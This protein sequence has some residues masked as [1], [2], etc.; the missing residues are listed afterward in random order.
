MLLWMSPSIISSFH[1]HIRLTCYW[2]PI[3]NVVLMSSSRRTWLIT[4]ESG[5][6]SREKKYKGY[7]ATFARNVPPAIDILTHSSFLHNTLKICKMGPRQ[8]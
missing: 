1:L 8:K 2:F 5:P 6:G 7:C 3:F 4:K